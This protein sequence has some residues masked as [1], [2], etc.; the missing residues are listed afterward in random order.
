MINDI[1]QNFTGALGHDY[2]YGFY[3][4]FTLAIIIYIIIDVFW[5]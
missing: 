3:V 4:F 2:I 5:Y 1:F